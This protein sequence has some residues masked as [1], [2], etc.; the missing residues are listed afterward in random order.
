MMLA[1]LDDDTLVVIIGAC[2][3]QELNAI[4]RTCRRLTQASTQRREIIKRLCVPPFDLD[5]SQVL[6]APRINFYRRQLQG[7]HMVMLSAALASGA[8]AQ[9]EVIWLSDNNIGDDGLRALSSAVAGGA[10]V[11]VTQLGIGGNNI[12]DAGLTT[13]AHAITPVSAGGSGALP[14]VEV[15]L[16]AINNVGDAGLSCLSEALAMG[17][18]Q[19]CTDLVLEGNEVG[20]VGLTALARAIMPVSAGGSG[21]LAS[22]QV[23]ACPT[24]ERLAL[25]VGMLALTPLCPDPGRNSTSVTIRLATTEQKPL[26]PPSPTAPWHGQKSS[27]CQITTSAMT[28]SERSLRLLPGGPWRRLPHSE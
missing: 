14:K 25:N 7:S 26:P 6:Y 28:A 4:S 15:L 12:T 5:F 13:L 20:D 18:L 9:T 23:C 19:H 22:V 3:L 1:F 17:A 24:P 10:L 16:L 21:A 2:R 11:Q 27:G 8:L